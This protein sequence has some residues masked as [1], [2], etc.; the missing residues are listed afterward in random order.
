MTLVP[1][2]GWRGGRPYVYLAPNHNGDQVAHF[3]M[4]VWSDEDHEGLATKLNDLVSPVF[5]RVYDGRAGLRRPRDKIPSPLP[6]QEVLL[7]L[8]EEREPGVL[9]YRKATPVR[10]KAGGL[11]GR[12]GVTVIGINYVVKFGLVFWSDEPAEEIASELNDLITPEIDA[13]Y[14]ARVGRVKPPRSD[15]RWFPPPVV[16]SAPLLRGRAL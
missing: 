12:E 11:S 6:S 7:D 15:R 14:A 16:S 2:G 8:F 9:Y 1:P 13:I 4:H 5:E 3:C 10:V